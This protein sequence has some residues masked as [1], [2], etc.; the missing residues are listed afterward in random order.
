MNS[1][2]F[3][4]PNWRRILIFIMIYI[5]LI[6]FVMTLGIVERN[7]EFT[8][9]KGVPFHYFSARGGA[10]EKDGIIQLIEFKAQF[11]LT[12]FISDVLLWGIVSYFLS[13]LIVWVYEKVKKKR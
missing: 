12:A 13:S 2:K 8:I 10:C 7:C 6:F 1:K 3:P 11:S 5:I 9:K 4:K